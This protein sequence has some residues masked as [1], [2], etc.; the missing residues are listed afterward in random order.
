[1]VLLRTVVVVGA[2][3]GLACLAWPSVEPTEATHAGT[4]HCAQDPTGNHWIDTGDLVQFTTAFGQSQPA[5]LDISP[6][7]FG[8]G[9]IDTADVTEVVG[10]FGTECYGATGCNPCGSEIT[11]AQAELIALGSPV[12]TRCGYYVKTVPYWKTPTYAYSQWSGGVTCEGYNLDATVRTRCIG[13]QWTYPASAFLTGSPYQDFAGVGCYSGV[14]GNGYP[15]ERFRGLRQR[16][17]FDVV[18][19]PG[20]RTLVPWNCNAQHIYYIN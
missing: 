9:F 17:C 3:L 4:P 12:V 20:G 8:D 7:P 10:D 2:A 13:D 11:A 16:L 18:W 5:Y 14:Y 19:P 1:M 15:F 6:A